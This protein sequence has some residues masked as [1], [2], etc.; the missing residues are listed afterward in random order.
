MQRPGLNIEPRLQ[1]IPTPDHQVVHNSLGSRR[2]HPPRSGW[3][4]P[5]TT[6]LDSQ[7]SNLTNNA[8]DQYQNYDL[9]VEIVCALPVTQPDAVS[10][11][12][13]YTNNITIPASTTTSQSPD[14]TSWTRHT[15]TGPKST[16]STPLQYLDLLREREKRI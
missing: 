8:N 4:L 7:Y 9:V 11:C 12:Q 10:A 5:R 13:N 15:I 14:P 16:Q 2:Q 1:S 6:T 3:R